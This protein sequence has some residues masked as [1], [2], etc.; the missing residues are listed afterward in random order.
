MPNSQRVQAPNILLNNPSRDEKLLYR[1]WKDTM[2]FGKLFVADFKKSQ[3]APTHYE[4]AKELDSGNTNPLGVIC[5]RSWAKTTIVRTFILRKVLYAE[6]AYR[7]G[8]AEEAESLFYGWVSQTQR[9]SMENVRF[10]A[11]HIEQHPKIKHYFGD[12][13]SRG[14]AGK[15]WTKEEIELTNNC[16]LKSTSNLS[17]MRGE[18]MSTIDRGALRYSGVFVDDSES[19][20]NTRTEA[21]RDLIKDTIM[22]GIYPA[23][24]QDKGRLVFIGTPVHYD[25]YA[26]NLIDTKLKAEATG[27]DSLW[28][29]F[30]IPIIDEEGNPSWPQMY[31]LEKIEQIRQRFIHSPKGLNG[32]LQEYMLIVQGKETAVF[33]EDHI[34]YHSYQFDYDEEEDVKFIVKGEEKI[35]VNIF[36]GCDPATDIATKT[37]DFSAIVVTAVDSDMNFYVIHYEHHRAIP[38]VALRDAEG[39]IKGKKGV[40]DYILDLYEYYHADSATVED[41]A[42][43]RTV[44]QA[45]EQ[46]KIR[47]NRFNYSVIPE[48][49]AGRNKLN[50]IYSYLAGHFSAMKIHFMEHMYELIKQT[51]HFGPYLPHDDLIEAFSFSILYAFPPKYIQKEGRWI[52]RRRKSRNKKRNW[53]DL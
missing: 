28:K 20:D 52:K 1:G 19:E 30:V 3:N 18:S 37:S 46:E 39:V 49:P 51:K 44:F 41:V 5:F 53:L 15:V 27:E 6:A 24:D 22:N 33:N 21:S 35:P 50:K 29:I 34:K 16:K 43:T 10:I 40:V 17:S 4:V 25:A 42:M 47:R 48:K 23:I 13:S 7:W 45:L 32:F 2:A 14:M 26:Q 9:K 8:W 11:M 38:T 36:I 31:S 12:L